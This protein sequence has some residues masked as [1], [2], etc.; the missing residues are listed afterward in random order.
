EATLFDCRP[1]KPAKFVKSLNLK[2]LALASSQRLAPLTAMA[3]GNADLAGAKVGPALLVCGFVGGSSGHSPDYAT[4]HMQ[5]GA[6]KETT[7]GAGQEGHQ[8]GNLFRPPDSANGDAEHFLDRAGFEG[9]QITLPIALLRCVSEVRFK[10]IRKD[11]ARRY[12]IDGDAAVFKPFRGT[13]HQA[14]Q[15]RFSGA[16]IGLTRYGV[17]ARRA[18]Y[19]DNATKPTLFHSRRQQLDESRRREEI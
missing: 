7:I 18:R 13:D 5:I 19:G 12:G 8:A 10:R 4:I 9:A 14:D 3:G 16:V 1:L 11:S 15:R 6:V 17:K 2:R